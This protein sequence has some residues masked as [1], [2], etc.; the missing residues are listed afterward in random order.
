MLAEFNKHTLSLV[1]QTTFF[2]FANMILH[3]CLTNAHLNEMQT[4]EMTMK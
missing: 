4:M 2:K 1:Y 3:Y